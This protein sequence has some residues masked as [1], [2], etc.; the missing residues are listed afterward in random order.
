[1]VSRHNEAEQI[2]RMPAVWLSPGSVSTA[3]NAVDDRLVRDVGQSPPVALA[4]G[5]MSLLEVPLEVRV[6][7]SLQADAARI[8]LALRAWLGRLGYRRLLSPETGLACTVRE[9]EA[10]AMTTATLADGV[11]EQRAGWIL[12]FSEAQDLT[13]RSET[14]VREDGITADTEEQ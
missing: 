4:V 7:S 9:N 3:F 6:I 13:L 1:V 2:E 5:G 8:A 10:P 11:A 14:L 12:A